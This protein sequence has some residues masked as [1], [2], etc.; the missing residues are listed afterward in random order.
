MSLRCSSARSISRSLLLL[1]SSSAASRSS[2]AS[3]QRL[4]R[5]G[6]GILPQPT[7]VIVQVAALGAMI[8]GIPFGDGQYAGS[9]FGW[10]HP[11]A[12]L[13]GIGLVLG[14]ALLGASW[15]VLKSDGELRDW[16]YAR[17]RWLAA[18]VLVVLFLA[19][20]F[21]FDY[22]VVAR[23]GLQARPWGLSVPAIACLA[24]VGIFIGRGRSMMAGR[25]R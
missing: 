16:A 10:L 6:L 11:F 7:V 20:A 9:V 24:L 21:T 8:R 18:G 25:L 5:L 2:S 19:F 23:S 12:I 15:L 1:G 13:T 14:Y 3:R 4:R 17:I 22:S